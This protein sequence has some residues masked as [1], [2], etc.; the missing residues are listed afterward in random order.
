MRNVVYLTDENYAMPTCVSMMSLIYNNQSN[1]EYK[2]YVIQNNVSEE[3]SSNF[4]ELENEYTHIEL[5]NV[6]NEKYADIAATCQ[7]QGIH[8]SETA[9]FKFDIPNLLPDVDKV[10]Y[11]DGDIIVNKDLTELFDE[12]ISEYYLAAVDD[13]GDEIF[14]D[15]KSQLAFQIGIEDRRYFNSGV[16]YL[17][18]ELLRQ[19]NMTE[20]LID[21]RVNK[22]NF[23]MDQDALNAVLGINR[24][25]LSYT[26]NFRT[27][28]FDVMLLEEVNER[29]FEK[30]YRDIEQCL[31]EQT[32]IHMTDKRKPWEYNV[33][34]ITD[35]FLFYYQL[36]P[37]K[38]TTLSLKSYVQ[39]MNNHLFEEKERVRTLSER[40]AKIKR[41]HLIKIWPFPFDRVRK[42]SRVILYG[43][44]DVG[45]DMYKQIRQTGYC[46]LVLWVDKNWEALG[47]E[48]QN[49]EDITKVDF[50]KIIVAVCD[51]QKICQIENYLYKLGVE[52]QKIIGEI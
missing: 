27:A 8:V 19:K 28:V 3:A 24:K 35:I 39:A 9:L 38:E 13:M 44:G 34:W 52:K 2:I 5:I 16:M 30:E 20:K 25:P 46:D 41:E 31:L 50:D 33:P 22:P 29:Y 14:A 23:F 36:C 45:Q 48:I 15:G 40:F 12:D 7:A 6:Q 43:A 47:E 42:G 51:N 37:Y 32:I 49:P 11:L 18:L 26:Y 21:Y 17:N 10:L 1:A 4:L